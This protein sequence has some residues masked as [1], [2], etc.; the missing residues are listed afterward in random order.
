MNKTKREIESDR[1]RAY[2]FETAYLLFGE[3]GYKALSTEELAKAAGISK[4]MVFSF[5]GSKKNLFE[6]VV[7][8]CLEKHKAITIEHIQSAETGIEAL[9]KAFMCGFNFAKSH[10]ESLHLFSMASRQVAMDVMLKHHSFWIDW[11]TEL[12]NR[13]QQE[14]T[15]TENINIPATAES[16]VCLHKVL[17]DKVFSEM[18]VK[19]VPQETLDAAIRMIIGGIIPRN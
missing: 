15:L 1:K 16:I 10:P 2:L 12:L 17:M 5:Y 7:D 3:K 6:A 8:Q 18:D 13:C 4:G 14:N 11:F 19:A 9:E